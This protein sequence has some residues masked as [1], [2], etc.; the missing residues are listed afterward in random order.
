MGIHSGLVVVGDLGL[1]THG[2]VTVV[3]APTQG[4]LRLQQQAAPGTLLVSAVTYHLVQ[5]EVHGTPC[6]SLTLDGWQAPLPVYAVQGLVQRRAG[7]PQRAPRY[8]SPFVGRERERALLH[9]RLEAV[10][11]GEGQVV[12][13]VG[14][15]GMGKTRLLTEFGRG[16]SPDQVTWSLGQCLAYG[17]MMPYLPVRDI[18]QHICALA[19]GDPLARRT[20]TVRRRLVA[21]GGVAEEDIALVLQLLGLPV[22]PELLGQRRPE[23]RQARTFAL[24]GHLIRHAAQH[25][26]LV[27]AVENVHWIDPT[28]EAWLAFLVERLAGMAVLLLLTHRPGYQ[29]PWG[30]HAA[31]TQLALPPLRAED[32]QAIVAAVPGTAQ[33]P[34]ARCQEI[35]AHGEGN[36]FFIEELAWY[37]VE[38]SLS[39]TRRDAFPSRST[40]SS[41]P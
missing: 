11:A 7:V 21:L 27:L 36:P 15:A 6:G 17:Q 18:V 35:V 38:H 24:L 4:A 39:A 19:E 40:S 41:M 3:G 10:R 30:T 8:R 13:L 14:P 31:V 2:Q 32:S 22:A 37:A 23:T 16:L 12:S 5:E 9:D 20:A 29:P 33:L 25:Q 26:P 1:A 34:A 28:S